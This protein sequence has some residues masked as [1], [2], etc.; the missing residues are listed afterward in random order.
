VNIRQRL[1]GFVLL[2]VVLSACA[3]PPT[4]PPAPTGVPRF[5]QADCWFKTP[6]SAE[7]ECGY[8]IVPEDHARPA[9]PT[10]KLAVARFRSD[11]G[12]PEPD[13][14]VYLEGGPGGSPLRLLVLQFDAY[15]SGLLKK[16]D[17]ILFDQRGTGYSQ[18]KLDCPEVKKVA[19]DTLD[20]NLSIDQST[21]LS[22]LAVAQC[23]DRLVKDGVNLA[24]YNSAQNAAD[25][26]ALRQ[27]LGYGQINLYGI[28]YGTRLA[29]T[30][31][32]DF[33]QGIRSAVIDG[34]E[35]LQTDTYAR[36]PANGA[37][38]LESVFKACE[39]EVV[40][41]QNY[42][43]LP[44]VLSDLKTQLDKDPIQ[45]EVAL[46]SG[47]KQ[48]VL[49]DGDG[50][51][52]TLFQGLYVTALI[53][54]FPRTIYDVRDGKYDMLAGLTSLVLS[55]LDDLS[56][57]MHFS[58]QCQEEAPFTN[59]GELDA[60][61]KQNPEYAALGQQDTLSACKLWNIPAAPALE[62]QGVTSDIPTLV[63]SGEFDPITPPAYGQ[64]AAQTL[65]QSFVFLVP[66]AG[67]GSSVTEDCPRSLVVAFFDNPAQKPEA[68]CLAEM[69]QMKFAVSM[70]VAD[71]KL[72]PFSEPQLG[73]SSVMPEDWKQIQS[74]LYSPSGKMTDLTILIVLAA[75]VA[76]ENF[77]S[78]M[79][80]QLSQADLK[81]EFEPTGT[82]TANG[83]AW[84]LYKSQ[85]DISGI[86][87]AIAKGG[88]LTYLV[89][90]QSPLSDRDVLYTAVFLPAV[91]ALKSGQGE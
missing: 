23:H 82:R 4:P 19:L 73:I 83:L 57:G 75:P 22:S 88:T 76:P 85:A 13:P 37:Q 66:R 30:V 2:S 33:P 56:Y 5:E 28:S 55:Q 74:G 41:N 8:L 10:I 71:F 84:T 12:Q 63:I 40:C 68:A 80:Q 44:Q 25:V 35:P 86:D 7:V 1:S 14:I 90:L 69:A 9:G 31:M 50:L 64:E 17:L 61:L 16:R 60:F 34:V 43:H 77:L 42:P 65:G 67:H 6:I 53:P 62:H 72:K 32:R 48:E 51:I 81:I 27:T 18:P 54:S 89:L 20:Q 38:A 24:A 39:A 11:S 21:K 87:L 36:T 26:E 70:K 15:L 91:D 45:F 46:H 29:L 52:G 78:L 59:I 3:T 47:E 58:V 79:Q 49:L